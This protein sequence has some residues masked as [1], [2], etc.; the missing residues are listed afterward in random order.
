MAGPSAISSRSGR[1]WI[2]GRPSRSTRQV[3]SALSMAHR[4]NIIHRDVKPHNIMMTRDGMAKLT[5]FGIA[6]AV[7]DSTLV[8]ETSRIIGSVHY[9]SPEQ[10]R[11]AYVDERSDI[12]SLGIVLYEMLTGQVPF[13]GDNPVQVALMHINDEITPPSQLVSG[14]PPAPGKAGHEGHRQVPVQPLP[15][16]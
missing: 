14:I 7:S 15:Q 8:T 10:A 6:K 11:G 3:A 4:N 2:T 12:Y 9:F 1:R 5:D 16:R 13:D